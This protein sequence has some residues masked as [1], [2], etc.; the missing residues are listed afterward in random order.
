MHVDIDGHRTKLSAPLWMFVVLGFAVMLPWTAYL[1]YEGDF[2]QLSARTRDLVLAAIGFSFL[3]AVYAFAR[4]SHAFMT[5]REIHSS[6]RY[7]FVCAIMGCLAGLWPLF[8]V[9]K[10]FCLRILDRM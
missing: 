1:R 7:Y 10:E 2:S 6:W 3:A 9:F 8:L 4:T 5:R